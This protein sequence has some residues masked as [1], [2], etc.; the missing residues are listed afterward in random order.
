MAAMMR[1]GGNRI[2]TA[3]MLGVS[4]KTV[5]NLMHSFGLK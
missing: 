4:L 2:K 1:T 5:Y 3:E